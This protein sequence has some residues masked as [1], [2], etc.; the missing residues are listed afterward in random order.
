MVS[1]KLYDV[2]G[3]EVKSGTGELD[4]IGQ[5]VS[6]TMSS[7]VFNIDLANMDLTGFPADGDVEISVR[8]GP[9]ELGYTPSFKKGASSAVTVSEDIVNRS[10]TDRGTVRYL[11]QRPG[12]KGTIYCSLGGYEIFDDTPFCGTLPKL[13]YTNAE[14][15][16]CTLNRQNGLSMSCADARQFGNVWLSVTELKNGNGTPFTGSVSVTL[17]GSGETGAAVSNGT[18]NIPLPGIDSGGEWTINLSSIGTSGTEL[19]N[20][21]VKMQFQ[22]NCGVEQVCNET[23]PGTNPNVET[24][25]FDLCSQVATG[26]EAH[27]QCVACQLEEEGVWT[28]VGCIPAEPSSLIKAVI[29]IGVGMGGGVALLM[30][31]IGGFL[32]TTSQGNPKQQETAKE[33]ITSAVIGLL[34]VMFSVV[35]LQFIGVTIF[36]IP[37]FGVQPEGTP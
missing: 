26:S 30:T 1:W 27:E 17:N 10:F 36:Q 18:F 3:A 28:A 9:I 31:L 4:S 20:C 6:G 8:R 7:L 29:T 23:N 13:Y 37:G 11:L 15:K 25:A 21:Q 22:D 24:A 12:P 19:R 5:I 32:L 14:N 16:Q 33:M 35:I 2:N 34:F